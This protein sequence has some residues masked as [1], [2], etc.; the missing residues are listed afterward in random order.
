[1]YDL[2]ADPNQT[3]KVFN[4]HPEIVAKMDARLKEIKENLTKH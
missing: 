3:Q 2:E 1:L 4:D